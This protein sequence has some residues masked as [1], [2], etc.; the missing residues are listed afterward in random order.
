MTETIRT[1]GKHLG[2]RHASHAIG[3]L[4]S[5]PASVAITPLEDTDDPHD[6]S[7][8]TAATIDGR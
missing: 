4:E 6:A 5:R 3:A 7:A 2:V 8:S 1:S